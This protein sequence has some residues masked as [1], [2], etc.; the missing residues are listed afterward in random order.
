[1]ADFC[2]WGTESHLRAR[3]T[4]LYLT[5]SVGHSLH[6]FSTYS[7]WKMLSSVTFCMRKHQKHQEY[8]CTIWQYTI[9]KSQAVTMIHKDFQH[10]APQETSQKLKESLF[11][12][13]F[14]EVSPFP[15]CGS[16][17]TLKFLPNMFNEIHKSHSYSLQDPNICTA[18]PPLIQSIPKVGLAT[19]KTFPPIPAPFSSNTIPLPTAH[20]Y[21]KPITDEAPQSATVT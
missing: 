2:C 18:V 15:C 11:Y 21:I 3:T 1:M 6:I 16:L 9:A 14:S 17:P 12:I 4:A 19:I 7:T 10:S 5:C 13:L 20:Y 8:I